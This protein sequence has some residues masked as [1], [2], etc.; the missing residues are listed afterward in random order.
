[1][2]SCFISSWD[3]QLHYSKQCRHQEALIHL[4]SL[5]LIFENSPESRNNH[6]ELQAEPPRQWGGKALG[7]QEK[8]GVP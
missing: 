1:M 2:Q 8:L 4:A 7:S 5:N 3:V 6:C